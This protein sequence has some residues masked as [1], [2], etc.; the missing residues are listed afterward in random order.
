[1]ARMSRRY[2]TAADTENRRLLSVLADKLAPAE[3]YR[4]AMYELG[5]GL[6]ERAC[7]GIGLD[8]PNVLVVGTVEDADF[9]ARGVLDAF[10]HAFNQ[11][12]FVCFWNDQIEPFGLK[13]FKSTPIIRRYEE[14]IPETID[15]LVVVKSIISSACVVKT[16]IMD[17][18]DRKSP[19]KIYILAPVMHVGAEERLR[20]AFS[21]NVSDKFKFIT[22]AVD[23]QRLSNGEIVPGIGGEVYSR[24]G[25][26][27]LSGKNSITP[28]V[29]K[30]RRCMIRKKLDSLRSSIT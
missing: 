30:E 3:K 22:F 27:C 28:T 25:F 13:E 20:E 5:C 4:Q 7:E 16:N 9:L 11:V 17:V 12:S 10:T 26:A 23:D 15:I 14:P 19:R 24:L 2:T 21:T 6:G 1:M 8:H 29:V 18:I